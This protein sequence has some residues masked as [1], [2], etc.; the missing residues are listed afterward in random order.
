MSSQQPL[1]EFNLKY[2]AYWL[3]PDGTLIPLLK[4]QTHE[5]WAAHAKRHPP[6]RQ[7]YANGLQAFGWL[8]VIH[9]TEHEMIVLGETQITQ[10]QLSILCDGAD[11]FRDLLVDASHG[12]KE[13]A[14]FRT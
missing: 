10:K 8:R 4:A 14:D 11:M 1:S 5:E 6:V 9:T 3:L 7:S 2:V 12:W 13:L